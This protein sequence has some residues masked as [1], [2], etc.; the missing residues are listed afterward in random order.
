MT[1]FKLFKTPNNKYKLRN[2]TKQSHTTDESFLYN[3]KDT[4]PLV[5]RVGFFIYNGLD[6]KVD[7][8]PIYNV[9]NNEQFPDAEGTTQTVS[10]GQ[11]ISIPIPRDH[12]Y[13]YYIGLEFQAQTTPTKGYMEGFA[14]IEYNYTT[15]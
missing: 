15:R 3:I 12:L 14:I 7:I 10:A 9:F 6:V 13:I 11:S 2:A 5:E 8:T 1:I 4:I